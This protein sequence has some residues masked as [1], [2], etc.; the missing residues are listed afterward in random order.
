MSGIGRLA[1]TSFLSAGSIGS[2]FVIVSLG[3][4]CMIDRCFDSR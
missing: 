1:R 3:L 4:T 2:E